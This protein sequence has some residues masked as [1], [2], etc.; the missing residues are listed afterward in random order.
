MLSHGGGL[1]AAW[2]LA[3]TPCI[4]ARQVGRALWRRDS[5]GRESPIVRTYSKSQAIG[6]G[7]EIL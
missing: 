4:G 6:E 7:R 5:K 3:P 2:I 1:E